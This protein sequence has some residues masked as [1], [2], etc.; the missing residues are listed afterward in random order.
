LDIS[1]ISGGMPSVAA[2][3]LAKALRPLPGKPLTAS[4]TGRRAAKLVRTA[5]AA[6]ATGQDD[7]TLCALSVCR[8]P[9]SERS[10]RK[11]P[12]SHAGTS[13]SA[14]NAAGSPGATDSV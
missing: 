14:T 11:S 7:G 3:A 5:S 12:Q 4:R 2:T 6:A 9:A 8:M 13:G 10:T 1:A